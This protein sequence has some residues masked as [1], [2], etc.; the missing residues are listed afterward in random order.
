MAMD[1]STWAKLPC[2][3]LYLIAET[4]DRQTLINW[5]CTNQVFYDF[6]SNILWEKITITTE[7]ILE[8]CKSHE[9]DWSLVDGSHTG[10][11]SRLA[12]FLG[13][14]CF[15]YSNRHYPGF[16][17]I[18]GEEAK[19]PTQRALK[20]RLHYTDHPNFKYIIDS[21]RLKS[22]NK[23]FSEIIASMPNLRF[24]ALDGPFQA[25]ILE[26][27]TFVLKNLRELRLRHGA[28]FVHHSI[29]SL[30]FDNPD[31]ILECD[32]TLPLQRL[33]YRTHLTRLQ[34]MRLAPREAES[35]ATAVS[36]LPHLTHLWINAAPAATED[37]PRKSFAGALK[38][39]SPIY[40]FLSALWRD[41]LSSKTSKVSPLPV[42]LTYL[43]LRDL[44]RAFPS[45]NKYLIYDCVSP[46]VHLKLLSLNFETTTPLSHF[47]Q[48]ATLPNLRR[49][50]VS[51]CR[52]VFSI[53]DWERLGIDTKDP[54]AKPEH[55]R[56]DPVYLKD[57]LLRHHKVLNA[58]TMSMI[59]SGGAVAFS[60]SRLEFS[61]RDNQLYWDGRESMA[62]HACNRNQWVWESRSWASSC[63][64]DDAEEGEIDCYVDG[65]WNWMFT[66]VSMDDLTEETDE[67]DG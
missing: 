32:Q 62:K 26:P 24:C 34:L 43:D 19:L 11:D 5:S 14:N 63:V 65:A 45:D 4:C 44:Y 58:L 20:L 56:N 54:V 66:G 40:G 1:P 64:A 23:A 31:E 60:K 27:L 52:H 21:S 10:P 35:L 3:I 67:S 37:D 28:E 9:S 57:F 8:Y 47:F 2:D 33:S 12:V 30:T 22:V 41:R 13:M 50:Q 29:P 49:L 25:E 38:D 51:A 18:L 16:P 7:Q 6:A 39:D 48:H 36:K 53:Q 55:H 42:T 15:R 61:K 59:D 46:L 17:T